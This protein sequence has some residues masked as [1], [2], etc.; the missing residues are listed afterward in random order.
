MLIHWTF[1]ARAADHGFSRFD[2]GRSSVG[3]GTYK[4][5]EQWGDK[6]GRL[7]LGHLGTARHRLA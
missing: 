5:K 3:E 4:F 2:F 7:G 1:L 6:A